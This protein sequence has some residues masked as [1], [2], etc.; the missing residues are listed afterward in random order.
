MGVP[1]DTPRDVS[2]LLFSDP[3]FTQLSAMLEG[4]DYAFPRAAKLGE[5]P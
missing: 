5:A 3:R 2:F 1:A 4:L